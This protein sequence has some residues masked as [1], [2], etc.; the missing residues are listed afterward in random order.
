MHC[1][2]L[3]KLFVIPEKTLF[4]I[5]CATYS[6]QM[7]IIFLPDHSKDFAS[8]KGKLGHCKYIHVPSI[9]LMKVLT[10]K[11]TDYFSDNI[12]INNF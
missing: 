1:L 8:L 9:K 5:N 3:Q 6:S 10:L 7:R 11:Q 2:S 4:V 12:I